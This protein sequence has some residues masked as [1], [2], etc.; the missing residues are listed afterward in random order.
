MLLSEA[1]APII[2][3]QESLAQNTKVYAKK[4]THLANKDKVAEIVS[5]ARTTWHSPSPK[6]V[7][8]PKKSCAIPTSSLPLK[9][10]KLPTFE[11]QQETL[12]QFQ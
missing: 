7:L 5:G 4:A 11:F 2:V 3:Q 1:G 6:T 9:K 10:R 12:C 8:Q